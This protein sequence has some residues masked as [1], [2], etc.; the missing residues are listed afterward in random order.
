MVQLI[1]PRNTAIP[2]VDLWQQ[3]FTQDVG[4]VNNERSNS[5]LTYDIDIA[6]W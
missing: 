3:F 5:T 1:N 6:V 2:A 4:F